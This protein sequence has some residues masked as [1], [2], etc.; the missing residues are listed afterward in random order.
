MEYT[1]DELLD[2]TQSDQ[3]LFGRILCV[4]GNGGIEESKPVFPTESNLVI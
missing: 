3:E 1:T 2:L 4:A